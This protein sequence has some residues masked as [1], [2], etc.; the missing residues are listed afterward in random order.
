MARPRRPVQ[1]LQEA[2]IPRLQPQ[3]APVALPSTVQ[4]PDDL[5]LYDFASISSSLAAHLR[6]Q[7]EKRN[8]KA[9]LVGEQFAE[10]NRLFM[11][12]LQADMAAVRKASQKT[13]PR[14]P[15]VQAHRKAKKPLGGSAGS[16]GG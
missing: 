14:R 9:E 1:S 15:S 13:L 6:R 7:Q 12:D 5:P 2:L 16:A 3:A 4:P 11:A 8:K 10:G